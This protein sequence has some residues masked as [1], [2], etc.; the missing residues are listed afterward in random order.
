M[1]LPTLSAAFAALCLA[2]PTTAQHGMEK[3]QVFGGPSQRACSSVILFGQNI[4]A[5]MTITHG[6]PVWQDKYTGMLNQ[7]K[8][9]TLRL[10][11]DLW[12]TFMTSVAV[13]IG[14][15]KV[16]AGSYCAGLV[17]DDAGNFSL[18]LIDSTT[19]MKKGLMPFGPQEWKPEVLIPLTLNKDVTKKSVEKM[20]M[21][22]VTE[23]DNP[24]KGMFTL[25]WGPHSLT[26]PMQ[27]HSEKK[28]AEASADKAGK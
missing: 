16:P 28:A 12:T 23:K 1:R 14:G 2:L 5:G 21:T 6:Q 20:T 8:G 15:T 7:L 4:M 10:G 3:M 19:T 9:K 24:M 26:A 11:K 22:L 17:C 18:A 27:V 13:E 25:A